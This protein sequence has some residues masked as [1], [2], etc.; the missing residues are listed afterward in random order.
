MRSPEL[1]CTARNG[2]GHASSRDDGLARATAAMDPGFFSRLPLNFKGG[3]N[4]ATGVATKRPISGGK[5]GAR[6]PLF[7]AIK[8]AG[9]TRMNCLERTVAE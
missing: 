1:R 9:L 6:V 5:I 8:G 3:K 4:R 7:F 2:G